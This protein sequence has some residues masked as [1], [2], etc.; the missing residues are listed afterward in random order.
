MAKLT[1]KAR[2]AIPAHDF[3]GPGRSYPIE[4]RSHAIAA[5]AR[6]TQA[7]SDGRISKVEM[8]RIHSKANAKL[9]GGR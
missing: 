3:A 1:S 5:K 9:K 8:Q 4:D 6:S 2:K 7:W